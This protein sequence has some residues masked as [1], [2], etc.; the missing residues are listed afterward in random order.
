MR[1]S[2][3]AVATGS[4][5]EHG[6]S[7]RTTSGSTASALAMHSLWLLTARQANSRLV[8]AVLHDVPQ[9]DMTKSRLRRLA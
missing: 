1:S 4:S 2:I 8:Q 3:L 9:G 5:A 7:I 6:S